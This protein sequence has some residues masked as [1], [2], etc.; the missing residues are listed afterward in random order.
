MDSSEL[1]ANG[2][3]VSRVGLAPIDKPRSYEGGDRRGP[4]PQPSLQPQSDVTH[5]SPS[6]CAR[7]FGLFMG[8]SVILR[9]TFVRC[10]LA[11]TSPVAVRCEGPEKAKA[12]YHQAVGT[13][14]STSA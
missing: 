9:R 7:L 12:T 11:C 4:N 6:W 2:P 10:V 8:F 5:Y 14:S 13:P 1:G 3:V